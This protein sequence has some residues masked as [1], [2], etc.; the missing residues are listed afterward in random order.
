MNIQD[1]V[2]IIREGAGTHFDERI[3]DLFLSITCDRIIDIILSDSDCALDANSRK[4]LE[5]HQLFE[6][7]VMI[8]KEVKTPEEQEF[9]DLFN[10]YYIHQSV[11]DKN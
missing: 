3:T 11:K 2:K 5:S 8:N 10:H 4:I 6:I 1:A 9:I 7:E